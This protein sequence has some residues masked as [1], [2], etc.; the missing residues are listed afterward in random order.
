MS[1]T[2]INTRNKNSSQSQNTGSSQ[3]LKDKVADAGAEIKQRAGGALKA[4]TDTAR[5]KFKEAADAA[6]D[7]GAGAADSFQ[8]QAREQQRSGAD[9]V[10]RLAGNI[11]DAARHSNKTC[12]SQPAASTRRPNM[13]TGPP[14]RSAMEASAI[15]SMARPILPSGSLRRFSG[16]RCWPALPLSAS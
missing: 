11:R 12:R 8:D 3:N 1:N 15:W 2:D 14:T 16:C 5:D 9:F 13:S 6:R 4:S 7:A 10:G